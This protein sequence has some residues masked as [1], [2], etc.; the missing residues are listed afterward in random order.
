MGPLKAN[1]PKPVRVRRNPPLS[2][3]PPRVR[4]RLGPPEAQFWVAERLILSLMIKLRFA[5]P[6]LMPEPPN[7]SVLPSATIVISGAGVR[8]PMEIP[9]QLV[10]APSVKF[11]VALV[12]LLSQAAISA[13]PGTA[14]L[15]GV[16]SS[17]QLEATF[18]GEPPL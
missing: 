11:P 8:L 15:A 13:A 7:V 18:K 2:T 4:V 17:V 5:L 10:D 6:M 3:V 16:V 9:S 14:T 1:D 12:S